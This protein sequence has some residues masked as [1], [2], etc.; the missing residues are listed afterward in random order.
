MKKRTA[1]AAALLLAMAALPRY[2]NAIENSRELAAACR[3]VERGA[4]G[5]GEQIRIPNTKGAL[6]CWGYMQAIQELSVLTDESGNRLLG[7]CPPQDTTSLQLLHA[8]TH[9]AKAHPDASEGNSILAVINALQDA[10]PC[11]MDHA[12]KDSPEAP[13]R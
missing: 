9:Y 8:F 6:L 2:A 5:E 3:A 11:D 12:A 4:T 1:L 13:R 10:F 7:S